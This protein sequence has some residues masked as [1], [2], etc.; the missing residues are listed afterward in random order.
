M[1]IFASEV[2]TMAI[3]AHRDVIVIGGSAAGL[4]A[5]LVLARAQLDVL[6][7]D[8]GEPRNAPAHHMHGFLSRDGIAPSEFISVGASEVVGYG[9]HIEKTKVMT[10]Q[11]RPDGLFYVQMENGRSETCRALLVATG[12]KDQIPSITGVQDRWGSLVH[13]CPY[14]HGYEVLNQRIAVIAGELKEMSIKQAGLLRRYSN[15]VVFLSNGQSLSR[16]EEASLERNGVQIISSLVSHIIGEVDTLTGVAFKDGSAIQC[17]SIF[18]APVMAPNDQILKSLNCLRNPK[19]DYV[20]VNE[21]G[22]TSV[23]GVWAAGNVVNPYAQVITAAGAGSASAIA[24]SGWLLQQD[25]NHLS[26]GNTE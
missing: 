23:P 12:L 13:H 15:H 22:Q 3:K 11:L 9:G 18:I 14:C 10:V 20:E 24:I 21:V 26:K 6:I 4:S 25:Q 5:A 8:S 19:T 17:D 1:R 16:S 2:V 7:I